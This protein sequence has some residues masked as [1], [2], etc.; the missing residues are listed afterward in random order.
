MPF[1]IV[2]TQ[3]NNIS[4]MLKI[5]GDTPQENLDILQWDQVTN[6]V[7]SPNGVLDAYM[8]SL[9]QERLDQ[10]LATI[11]PADLPNMQ[12]AL[13]AV[14]TFCDLTGIATPLGVMDGTVSKIQLVG[15]LPGQATYVVAAIP[16]SIAPYQLSS[17]Q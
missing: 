17:P 14:A 3:L 5:T 11:D 2:P 4:R 7:S 15:F 12:Y 8:V 1:A 9:A 6:V 10:L 13:G 16:H